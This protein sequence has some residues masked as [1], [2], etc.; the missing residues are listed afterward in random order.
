ME[1]NA[2]MHHYIVTLIEMCFCNWQWMSVIDGKIY[3]SYNYHID[4]ETLFT[5]R[6]YL[7]LYHK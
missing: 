2:A 3:E 1:A 4:R 6:Q 7:T 5:S